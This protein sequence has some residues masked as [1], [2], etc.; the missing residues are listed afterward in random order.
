MHPHGKTTQFQLKTPRPVPD[1]EINSPNTPQD[2]LKS[3]RLLV[4]EFI[5]AI[6]GTGIP[7]AKT[8][9]YSK[10][11]FLST[12][13]NDWELF[14]QTNLAIGDVIYVPAGNRECTGGARTVGGT[15]CYWSN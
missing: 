7:A 4:P 9:R 2:K 8:W 6:P 5:P 3:D 15:W 10:S 12:G 11:D 14:I 13:P 1:R